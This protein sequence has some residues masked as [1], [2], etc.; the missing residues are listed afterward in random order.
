MS[1]FVFQHICHSALIL[2]LGGLWEPG[3]FFCRVGGHY[4]W[5]LWQDELL[6]YCTYADGAWMANNH[7]WL[8]PP[9]KNRHQCQEIQRAYLLARIDDVFLL[10]GI[11][12]GLEQEIKNLKQYGLID[13]YFWPPLRLCWDQTGSC[14][15]QRRCL[16]YLLWRI[17]YE[18]S[19]MNNLVLSKVWKVQGPEIS[20]S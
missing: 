2:T 12:Q 1:A 18:G 16:W 11:D 10:L 20:I 14:I 13:W 8:S 15:Y 19:K 3:I 9:G 7:D 5:C 4:I 6:I 17:V